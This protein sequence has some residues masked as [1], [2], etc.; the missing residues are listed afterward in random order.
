VLRQAGVDGHNR[1]KWATREMANARARPERC[2][3]GKVSI[4]KVAVLC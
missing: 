4:G 3:P 2:R 1:T